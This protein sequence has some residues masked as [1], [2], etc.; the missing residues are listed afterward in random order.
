MAGTARAFLTDVIRTDGFVAPEGLSHELRITRTELAIASGLSREA[1]FKTTRV[2]GR[3]TQAR[4]RDIVEI[5]NRV[6]P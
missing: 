5:I 3:A 4:L 6:L 1:V 2:K